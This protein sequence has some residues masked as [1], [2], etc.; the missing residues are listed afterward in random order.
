MTIFVSCNTP[1]NIITQIDLD[2]YDKELKP[3]MTQDD[4]NAVVQRKRD[5]VEQNSIGRKIPNV[6]IKHLDGTVTALT[7]IINKKTILALTGVHCSWGMTGLAEDLPKVEKKLKENKVDFDLICLIIKD[8]A[9][10]QDTK[11]FDDAL[12]SLKIIYS[13]IYIIDKWES[14]KLNVFAN[15][16]RLIINKNKI[17]EYIGIGVSTADGLYRELEIVT[18]DDYWTNHQKKKKN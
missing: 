17:L 13:K 11:I 9:D 4:I 7:R 12:T 15:P 8:S 6:I 3:G 16:T 14:D 10:Y 18:A 1:T 5:E 2:K